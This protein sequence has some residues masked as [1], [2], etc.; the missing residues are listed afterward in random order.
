MCQ[1]PSLPLSCTERCRPHTTRAHHSWVL[2]SAR[3][4]PSTVPHSA[5]LGPS[6]AL[7]STSSLRGVPD[8]APAAPFFLLCF[9]ASSR[10][11]PRFLHLPPL[12]PPPFFSSNHVAKLPLPPAPV[13]GSQSHSP[14]L[15]SIEKSPPLPL[16]SEPLPAFHSSSIGSV[17]HPLPP[18]PE[19]QDN[20]GALGD[21]RSVT[22]APPDFVAPSLPRC[23][24]AVPPP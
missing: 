23:D 14:T 22:I 11:T 19:L 21:R 12:R 16:H 1:R 8:P 15:G 20:P 9:D 18:F 5:A 24:R 2:S 6:A 10:S 3:P 17:P 7:S 13:V 4:P